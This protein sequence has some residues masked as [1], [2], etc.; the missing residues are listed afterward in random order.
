MIT[1]NY[2]AIGDVTPEIEYEERLSFGKNFDELA[3]IRDALLHEL[4]IDICW[5][6]FKRKAQSQEQPAPGFRLACENQ[7]T[8]FQAKMTYNY[9]VATTEK[10]APK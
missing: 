2:H 3:G 6:S 7:M 9:R 1:A 5:N 10:F 8:L 4:L